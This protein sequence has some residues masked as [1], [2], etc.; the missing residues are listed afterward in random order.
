MKVH[1][2]PLLDQRE[3]SPLAQAIE[4]GMTKR[5]ARLEAG[6]GIAPRAPTTSHGGSAPLKRSQSCEP[7]GRPT[8]VPADWLGSAG[9]LDR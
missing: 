5:S 3:G 9:G 4:S 8:S 7:G 1:V 6:C 2:T